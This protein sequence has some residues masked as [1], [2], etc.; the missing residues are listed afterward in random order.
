MWRMYV[1]QWQCE[2]ECECEW[3]SFAAKWSGTLDVGWT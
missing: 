2:S 1:G 3:S